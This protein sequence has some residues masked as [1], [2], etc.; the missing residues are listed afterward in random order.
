M[1]KKGNLY[2]TFIVMLVIFMIGVKFIPFM[3]DG[4]DNFRTTYQ[5]SGTTVTYWNTTSQS[6]YTVTVSDG[7]KLACLIV[8]TA[9]PY[10]IVVL[11]SLCGGALAN[12]L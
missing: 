5:C 3:E 1:N 8:D 6:N 7:S 2:L 11:L 12:E 10:F 9:I 4:V